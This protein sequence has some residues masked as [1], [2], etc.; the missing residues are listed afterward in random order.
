MYV[1]ADFG[2][3][4]A[5]AV[6]LAGPYE[7]PAGPSFSRKQALAWDGEW[8]KAPLEEGDVVTK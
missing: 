5:K 4:A 6:E 2:A 8:L 1:E 7:A 3:A